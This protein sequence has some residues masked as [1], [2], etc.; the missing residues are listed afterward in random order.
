LIAAWTRVLY[1]FFLDHA[2]LGER[3]VLRV[4]VTPSLRYDLDRLDRE[5]AVE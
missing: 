1:S 5:G 4:R 3:E 2:R